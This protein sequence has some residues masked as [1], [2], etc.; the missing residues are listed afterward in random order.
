MIGLSSLSKVNIFLGVIIISTLATFWLEINGASLT[1]QL[2]AISLT[3]LFIAISIFYNIK[4]GR[5][6]SKLYQVSESIS[7]GDFNQRFAVHGEKGKIRKALNSINSMIDVN[8]AFVREASLA[9]SAASEGKFYRKI[10]TEGMQGMFLLSINKINDAIDEM[11][12]AEGNRSEVIGE[13]R[14]QLGGT[15][16]AAIGG[17]FTKRLKIQRAEDEF[18]IIAKQVNDLVGVV[19]RGVKENGKV[20]SALARMDLTYRVKGD[21]RGSFLQLKNDTNAVADKLS[22]V[23]GQL[24]Q[25]SNSLKSATSEILQG[26][27][28]L[29]KRTN[30]QA[31]I[32]EESSASIEE[33]SETVL[34]SAKQADCTSIKSKKLAITAADT[35]EI[36]KKATNAMERI[37]TSSDKI[38][39]VIGMIDDIAFQTNLLALNASV[40]AARAGEAGKGFAVVAVEV[41]RLAQSAANA[42]SEVKTL[43]EQSINEVD[44]G[45]EH[46]S[47]A[48]QRI[49]L[50]IKKIHENSSSMQK[51]AK[52][53]KQQASSIDKVN[54]AVRQMDDMTQQ[55]VALVE[56][57]SA[58]IA[59]TDNQVIEL[60]IIVE[61]FK[62][63]ASAKE[64]AQR[65]KVAEKANSHNYN[66]RANDKKISIGNSSN[67]IQNS[68]S[69]KAS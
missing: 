68:L 44:A 8:D 63:E 22:E 37:S 50:M 47:N 26:A 6:F 4:T 42:S 57:T 41:R 23:M 30:V 28:D 56:E 25:T 10:R 33:L 48:A 16:E 20:L 66:R 9:L 43:I 52:D 38:S 2:I 17:D 59:Q 55:N 65:K 62:L 1:Q 5:V 39:N 51:I 40:E 15:I 58:A 14:S 18:S 60:D 36:V 24:S 67:N 21:F 31:A 32:A 46:V 11:K 69:I 53:S 13:L 49:E 61:T 34:Q 64:L 19:N 12:K 7:I 35:G 45:T 54:E 27:N 3:I 29:S